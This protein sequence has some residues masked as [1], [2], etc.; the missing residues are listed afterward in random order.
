[1]TYFPIALY[2]RIKKG[3]EVIAFE[4]LAVNL[5]NLSMSNP[6]KKSQIRW[7]IL[8]QKRDVKI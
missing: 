8:H 3:L 1:M 6:R 5:K 7:N 4:N 2:H